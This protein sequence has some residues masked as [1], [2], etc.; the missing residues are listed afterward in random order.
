MNTILNAKQYLIIFLV[1]NLLIIN[2]FMYFRYRHLF[3]DLVERVTQKI[4]TFGSINDETY[5]DDVSICNNIV[6]N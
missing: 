4:N 1:S 6:A 3:L 2:N 5:D